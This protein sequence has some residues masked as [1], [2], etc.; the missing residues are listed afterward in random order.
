VLREPLSA[1]PSDLANIVP[2]TV[3]SFS[4]PVQRQDICSTDAAPQIE[5]SDTSACPGA[6]VTLRLVPSG[7]KVYTLSAPGALP[8]SVQVSDSTTLCFPEEGTYSLLLEDGDCIRTQVSYTVR[9][10]FPGP[11][12]LSDTLICPGRCITAS[13]PETDGQENYVWEFEGGQPETYAGLTPP[14]VCFNTAGNY[15]IR[16]NIAGCGFTADTLEVSSKPFQIPNAFTPNGDGSNDL[17]RPLLECPDGDYRFEVYNRWGQKV[18]S[19]TE[20]AQAFPR[21]QR[22]P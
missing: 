12:V 16:L 21:A 10:R 3:P 11:V 1:T 19:S 8:A 4:N 18:F 13:S 9:Q 20:S 22:S 14:E 17:F 6:C 2:V 15:T 7:T 5:W